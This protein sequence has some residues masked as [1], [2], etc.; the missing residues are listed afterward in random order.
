ML[1]GVY[2]KYTAYLTYMQLDKKQR[3]LIRPLFPQVKF[4]DHLQSQSM[5]LPMQPPGTP[6]TSQHISSAG[7]L[8]SFSAPSS[9]PHLQLSSF[10]APLL[11]NAFSAPLLQNAFSAPL[12]PL[13]GSQQS[14]FESLQGFLGAQQAMSGPPYALPQHLPGFSSPA[15]AVSQP[16]ATS[17][18]PQRCSQPPQGPLKPS[19]G[20]L[21]QQAPSSTESPPREEDEKRSQGSQPE[22]AAAADQPQS[23][24]EKELPADDR[25]SPEVSKA[26][27][28]QG[29]VTAQQLLSDDSARMDSEDAKPAAQQSEELAQPPFNTAPSAELTQHMQS[30]EVEEG[31][32]APISEAAKAEPPVSEPMEVEQ[33]GTLE[34]AEVQNPEQSKEG[35]PGANLSAESLQKEAQVDQASLPGMLKKRRTSHDDQ[36]IAEALLGLRAAK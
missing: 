13:S 36:Q 5:P 8:P 20:S 26:D 18:L 30:T 19:P 28:P 27:P 14:F 23:S 12:Q 31:P 29:L 2:K 7:H 3:M 17:Q 33:S 24:A 16:P 1:G 22:E 11:Q 32:K 25:K 4:P 9:Q 6:P 35:V 15:P 34:S 10:S 21:Q